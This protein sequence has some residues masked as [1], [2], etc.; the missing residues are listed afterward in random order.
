MPYQR[1][2][3]FATLI[4]LQTPSDIKSLFDEFKETMSEDYIHQD[5]QR[6]NDPTITFEDRHMHHLLWHIDTNLRVHGKSITDADFADL[7]QLPSNFVHS[8]H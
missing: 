6:L 2:Q 7:P 1:R 8:C 5:Q 3:L 4:V